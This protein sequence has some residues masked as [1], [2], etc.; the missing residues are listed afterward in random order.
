MVRGKVTENIFHAL[1]VHRHRGLT[2]RELVE[3]AYADDPDGGPED[4][5]NSI[6]VLIYLLNWR[7][8]RPLGAQIVAEG[9]RGGRN[10]RRKLTIL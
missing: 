10:A 7:H 5:I 3:H 6:S 1:F 8:L 9:D 4:A 2:I